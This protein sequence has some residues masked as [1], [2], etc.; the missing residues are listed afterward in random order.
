M[1]QRDGA[2]SGVPASL[3]TKVQPAGMQIENPPDPPT[4]F[5]PVPH[6]A[7]SVQVF[8]Q[9]LPNSPSDGAIAYIRDWSTGT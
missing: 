9:K 4:Q 6:E 8:E 7:S 2:A 1:A 5:A 3:A